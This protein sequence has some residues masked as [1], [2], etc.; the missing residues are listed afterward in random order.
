MCRY[1]LVID[2]I[3]DISVWQTIR[4]ALPDNDIGYIIITTTRNFGVAEEVGGAY[5]LKPL[6]LSNSQK[7]LYRRI[8][9]NENKDNIEDI[10]K[11]LNK[12][13]A[14]VSKRI[15]QKCGGVPLAIVTT[16]S[17]LASKARNEIDWYDVYNSIGT[18]LSD[19]TDVVNMR[20][21]LSLSYYEMPSHL[22]TCLLYLSVFP[23]DYKIEKDRL[24]W[25]WIAEGFIQC[26][27]QGKSLFA[28]GDSYFNELMNRSMIQPI[29]ERYTGLIYACHVHDMVHD[30]ICFLSSEENLVTILNGVWYTSPS[31]LF[32]R[33][34]LQY[35]KE[36]NAKPLHIASLVHVRS[37]VVF[38]SAFCVMPVLRRFRVLRVL[39]L[40]D[41]DLSRG[42][43]LEFLV[44]LFHL[45]YLGLCATH[46]AQLP[47]QIGNLKFLQTLDVRGNNMFSLPSTVVQLT[48]LMCLYIDEFT[49]VPNG[50]GSLTNLEVLSTLDITVSIDI[51]EELGQLMKLRV[52]HILLFIGWSGKLVECQHKL[53]NIYPISIHQDLWRSSM[54]L[55]WIGCLGC[56]STSL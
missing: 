23:E 28:I 38:A 56:P 30:L 4:R 13:L 35:G 31:K 49:R 34:S 18:G 8:F 26:E 3:W 41:C 43:S 47:Q 42:Y 22:R 39:N 40:Q 17:L 44:H 10:E 48:N 12:E 37:A 54:G 32:G 55:W 52:L 20:K 5:K 19:S 16:A 29:Y 46:I 53:Q 9:G 2:D 27:N 51:I 50:I 24:I 14:E 11:C 33:L 7:L 15:L 36:D 1:F 25:M 21:I 45:R 6:S